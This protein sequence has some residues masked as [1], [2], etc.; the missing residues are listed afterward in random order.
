MTRASASSVNAQALSYR[1]KLMNLL[2]IE[3]ANL[4]KGTFP[5]P[6]NG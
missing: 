4:L 6:Y 5:L 2:S 1:S 3:S